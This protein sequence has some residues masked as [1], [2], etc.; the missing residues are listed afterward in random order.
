MSIVIDYETSPEMKNKARKAMK[1]FSDLD[2]NGN[3]WFIYSPEEDQVFTSSFDNVKRIIANDAV[4]SIAV[5]TKDFQF[6]QEFPHRYMTKKNVFKPFIEKIKVT[7]PP[8]TK[9]VKN[10]MALIFIISM[11][12]S[13]VAAILSLFGGEFLGAL[14]FFFLSAIFNGLAKGLGA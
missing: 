9:K 6:I 11:G 7:S 4:V 13:F 2:A 1:I 5:F 14:G 8:K 3:K 12:A 10:I